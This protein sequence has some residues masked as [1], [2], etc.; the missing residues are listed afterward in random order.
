MICEKEIAVGIK[1]IVGGPIIDICSECLTKYECKKIE[2][3]DV[4]KINNH[5]DLIEV[6]NIGD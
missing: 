4:Y 2:V 5:L 3:T 1:A 6:V